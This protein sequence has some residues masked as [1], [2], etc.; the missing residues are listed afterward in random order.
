MA[1][2]EPI[3][4]PVKL[5]I[6][7]IRKQ[8]KQIQGEIANTFDPEEIAKLSE[9]AGELRDNLT[10]VNEQVGI[11]A[12]GSPFEQS[13]NALGL[14]GSQLASLDFEG[15]AESAQLLQSK[16]NSI[17]PDQ[18]TK[19]MQGLTD[20][21]STLGKVSGSAIMGVIKNVGALSKAFMSFGLSLLANP[22]FLIAAVIVAI[23][24]AITALLNKLGVLK[25]VLDAIGKVFE[26]IGW[27]IDKIV[28]G[29]N[30]LTDAIGF[31]DIAAEDS[32][33]RQTAAAERVADAYDKRAKK[34]TGALEEEIKINQINGKSTF[35]LELKKQEVIRQGAQYRIKALEAKVKEAKLTGELDA[36]E[37]KALREKIA[38]Q[39]ELFTQSL[40]D[41]RVL[42]AQENADR[43]KAQEEQ[44]KEEAANA[45][46]AAANA[47]KYAADRLAAQRQVID[48]ELANIEDGV[49]KELKLNAEKY[50][51]L[52]EDTAKNESLTASEKNRIKKLL[53]EQA[54]IEEDK[55]K[56]DE[57]KRRKEEAAAEIAEINKALDEANAARAEAARR[58]SMAAAELRAKKNAD[59]LSAQ[60][61]LLEAKKK[62]ELENTK[63]TES[64]KALIE[65]QFRQDK[66]KLEQEAA[67][68]QAAI[69]KAQVDA[70]RQL[71]QSSLNAAQGVADLVFQIKKDRAEKGSAAEEKAARQQFKVN[72]AL[73]L[74][75][76]TMSAIQ[77]VQSALAQPTL[78]PDPIGSILK[79]ANAAAVG[80][81][82][83][84]N[85][86]KIAAAKF[87]GVGAGG[88]ASPQSGGGA[89]ATASAA[90]S[91]NLFG[92]ANQ[93]NNT[94]QGQAVEKPAN[95]QITV[96]A[97]V[98][99]DEMTA[100]QEIANSILA[101]S[102]L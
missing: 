7:E 90:P 11:Y 82:G 77:G 58:E 97:V 51:R 63:L 37:I 100:E 2:Q 92:N 83:A 93:F 46:E 43:K 30:K 47:K 38:A 24:V 78:V 64:E 27:V 29:F 94:S 41:T 84:A 71:L 91:F 67:D 57:E 55:I 6:G 48:L 12:S 33:K 75:S 8:L 42:R 81:A 96:K 36:E 31:T 34:V 98:A 17:T 23:V 28:E 80:V 20:T 60:I 65:E 73:Q 10:R 16:I 66:I 19:Q 87:E 95:Q 15:A 102:K 49:E 35:D 39:R 50:R 4:I 54:K 26:W 72:K 74:V 32:A 22:I 40:S 44:K 70:E 61:A 52:I 88:A 56:T 53:A 79:F 68:K 86:A 89:N 99:A 18:V 101:G 3:E 21:F 13:A 5:S 76:A 85:V 1:T 59:D 9:K 69:K 25:P 14:V 62:A 45:K